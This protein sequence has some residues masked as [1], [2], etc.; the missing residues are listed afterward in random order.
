MDGEQVVAA[1][2]DLYQVERSFRMAKS[3]LAARPI[4]HRLARQHRSPPDHR[5]RRARGLPRGPSPHRG[6]DQQDREDTAAAANRHHHPRP[7]ADH[8]PT[9]HPRPRPNASSTTSLAV[10]TKPIQLRPVLR[11]ACPAA[12]RQGERT[13][14]ST[15]PSGC[16]WRRGHRK[17][18]DAAPTS[19]AHQLPGASGL[20]DPFHGLTCR[21]DWYRT[22]DDPTLLEIARQHGKSAAPGDAPLAPAAESAARRPRGATSTKEIDV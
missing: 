14:R 19:V 5:V 18:V 13:R 21:I 1:Y 2:H 9:T 17:I 22:F 7:P 8:R 3:D 10:V 11:R 16:Y 12:S 6:V 4:F 15:S 20:L